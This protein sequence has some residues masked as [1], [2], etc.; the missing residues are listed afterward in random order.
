LESDP[1]YF[2]GFVRRAGAAILDAI[3]VSIPGA[4]A[5]QVGMTTGAFWADLAIESLVW[6]PYYVG[7]HAS[8]WQA[9]PGKQA[10]G[11][12]VTDLEGRRIGM[13]RSLGR[14]LA[15]YLSALALL[16]GFL[17]VP[18]TRR[19]QAL[20]DMI[21]GT[22]VVDAA[23]EPGVVPFD[24]QVMPLPG[25]VIALVAMVGCFFLL[26][27]WVTAFVLP[28]AQEQN[29]VTEGIPASAAGGDPK[30][31]GYA[32][33][34]FPFFG[35]AP[36]LEKEGTLTYRL[37]DVRVPALPDPMQTP[38]RL[39]IVDG[40][41]IVAQIQRE[42]ALR[43]FGLQLEKGVG[44]SWEWFDRE[45]GQ[46]YVFRKRLGGG[47]VQVR[48]NNVEGMEEIAEVLFLDDIVLHVDRN[49][50]VPFTG[51]ATEQLVVRKGSVLKVAE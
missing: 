5:H 45:A 21:A 22:L 27:L 47:R 38:K 15:S 46:D 29:Q 37:S 48:L 30:A 10:F 36:K 51:P 23:Q 35:G 3:L 17:M 4:I 14:Y 32:L 2:A 19:S 6:I 28:S 7:F 9:T 43:G 50:L 13:G 16:V 11:I 20:H 25:R 33:Y 34:A 41:T 39:A 1:I 18:F 12:K 42:P 49:F 44:F 26:Y 24:R 31:L 8:P 40:F